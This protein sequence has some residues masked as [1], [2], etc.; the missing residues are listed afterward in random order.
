MEHPYQAVVGELLAGLSVSLDHISICVRDLDTAA[1]AWGS[2]LGCQP[3]DRQQVTAQKTEV[4]F[5]RPGAGAHGAAVELISP[6]AGN[7]GLE[8]FLDQRGDAIHHIA[9]A[10]SDIHAA[11]DRLAAAGVRLIDTAPRP[12]ACGHTVAFLHPRAMNG[13]LIELVQH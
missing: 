4:V 8:K 11:L 10:V 1:R 2:L 12:G 3:A 7:A 5:L 9:F 13:T 6:M